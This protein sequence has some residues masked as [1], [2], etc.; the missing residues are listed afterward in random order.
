MT[1]NI[2][3]KRAA[4]SA[5][6]SWTIFGRLRIGSR[7]AVVNG[8]SPIA[9]DGPRED[10]EAALAEARRWFSPAPAHDIL[11]AIG[12]LML[13]TRTRND[14]S[15]DR[16]AVL[17]LY[18]RAL[19]DYPGDIALAAIGGYR[20]IFFPALDEIRS[21]IEASPALGRRRRTAEAIERFLSQPAASPKQ[22]ITR[23]QL[24]DLRARYGFQAGAAA[25]MLSA[26]CD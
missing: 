18:A 26:A 24:D 6:E 15:E 16:Q 12:E 17:G 1:G 25:R 7:T 2:Q 5:P 20:G 3:E 9:V 22:R 4:A 14:D 8:E 23:R 21:A 13:R 11:E 10:A 19:G